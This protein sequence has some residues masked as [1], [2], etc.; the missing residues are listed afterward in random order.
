VVVGGHVIDSSDYA[1]YSSV[2][3]N[4]SVR[5]LFLAAAHQGLG[6]MT[7]DIGNAFPTAPCAEEVWSKCG[8]EF[9]PQEGAIVTLQRAL[10]GLKT[11][12]KDLSMSSLVIL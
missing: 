8:P 10:Y 9:G 3:E 1:T 5:L 12:S 2:I 4:L 11:A 6:I 7:G